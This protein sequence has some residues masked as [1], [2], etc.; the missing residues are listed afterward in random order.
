[1]KNKSLRILLATNSMVLISVAML[2]PIYA[3][4][5]EKIGGDILD[6]SFAYALFAIFA[7]ATTFISGRFADKIKESELIVALGYL[8]ISVG[9]AGYIWVNSMATLF[10]IQILI[11][12]GE[13]I[14]SPAFDTLYSRHLDS[15]QEGKEWGMWESINYFTMGTGAL[16][17]G[18]LVTSF[19]FNVMFAVMS[20]LSLASAMYIIR[21]PRNVL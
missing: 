6:A 16:F 12:I 17:G 2:G 9:F 7:G 13:A 15:H 19:G 5:I 10:I 3:I 1:M 11:G 4:F 18:I 14:Y 20:M 8:L 21:L